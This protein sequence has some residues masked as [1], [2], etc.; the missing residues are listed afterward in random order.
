MHITANTEKR[1][2]PHGLQNRRR[3]VDDANRVVIQIG[4]FGW[5]SEEYRT[6]YYIEAKNLYCHSF[7]KTGNTSIT[8]PGKYAQR[9]IDTGIDNLLNGHYPSN[10][11]LLGYVLVG[12]VGEAVDLLN[13]YLTKRTR[14]T[15]MI[16]LRNYMELLVRK[17]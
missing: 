15:E 9:Y 1:L 2:L 17:R 7:T 12:A 16:A 6:V 10:T 13:Q 8:S 14:S 3:S 11:L 4:G 5:S